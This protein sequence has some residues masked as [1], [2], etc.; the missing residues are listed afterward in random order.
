ME[1][2]GT[3]IDAVFNEARD[4]RRPAMQVV[5]T[6]LRKSFHEMAISVQ[7]LA[8]GPKT[9]VW[10]DT[11][12]SV[13]GFPRFFVL[14]ESN[15]EGIDGYPLFTVRQAYSVRFD[16]WISMSSLVLGPDSNAVANSIALIM[17]NQAGAFAGVKYTNGVVAANK[18]S[19]LAAMVAV[20]RL[21]SS[22]A[23]IIDSTEINEMLEEAD[24]A[25]DTAKRIMN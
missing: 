2:T 7:E 23:P 21:L 22:P 14:T 13:I 18:S 11:E 25:L 15:S 24:T 19:P 20:Q 17:A 10:E 6:T 12:M 16:S 1:T 3:D 4:S 9:W 5:V 8:S